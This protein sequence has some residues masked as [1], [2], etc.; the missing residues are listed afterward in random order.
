M[1]TC[2]AIDDEPIA[3]DI[4]RDYI[5]KAGFLEFKGAFRSAV[6]ALSFMTENRV[7]LVFLD[8]NMP[9]LN[10]IQFAR[11]LPV[12]KP[13]IVFCSAYAKYAVESYE[14]DALDYL[15]KPIE[16]ERFMKA[17]LKAKLGSDSRIKNTQPRDLPTKVNSSPEFILVKSGTETQKIDLKDIFFIEGTG[18][19]VTIQT[20]TKRILSLQSM[21]ELMGQ[22]PEED[23]FRIHKSYI[24]SFRCLD[25]IENH[26]VKIGNKAFPIGSTYRN[27][28]RNWLN[29]Q[30]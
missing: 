23:F 17:V 7:D 5:S 19:Y 4:L 27:E 22:L 18:N 30:R 1:I 24:V 16:L 11:L 21:K 14:L 2:I 10:G 29:R 9:E 8:I 28:F 12:P 6:D 26:Q 25:T 3:L 20:S 13:F 15:L